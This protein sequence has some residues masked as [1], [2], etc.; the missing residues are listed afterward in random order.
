MTFTCNAQK[1]KETLSFFQVALLGMREI[2]VLQNIKSFVEGKR[3]STLFVHE[4]SCLNI[5][6]V[7]ISCHFVTFRA[8]VHSCNRHIPHSELQW[9]NCS[10]LNKYSSGII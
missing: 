6:V 5:C 2:I 7:H 4:M 3:F 8:A 10:T 1:A 9:K